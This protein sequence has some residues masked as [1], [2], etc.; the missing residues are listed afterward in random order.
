LNYPLKGLFFAL[1]GTIGQA[2]GLV[3]S[4]YGMREYDPFA[5][6]HIRIMAGMVGFAVIVIMLRKHDLINRAMKDKRGLS[7]IT[8]GSIFGPFLGVSFS[9]VAVQ[10]TATGIAATLMS[11]MPVL[12]IPPSIMFFK[13][14]ITWPEIAGAFLSVT[15]VALFFIQF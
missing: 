7:F 10:N 11:L 1:L 9:L 6:T 15:G 3:L 5:S 4:K 12:L 14:K 8:L 2:V 13:H